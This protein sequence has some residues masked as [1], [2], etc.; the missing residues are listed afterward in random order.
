MTIRNFEQQTKHSIPCMAYRL[1]YV[2]ALIDTRRTLGLATQW[3]I[4]VHKRA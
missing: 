3:G 4:T 1:V 2:S